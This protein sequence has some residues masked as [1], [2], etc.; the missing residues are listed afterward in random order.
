MPEQL[1]SRN[2]EFLRNYDPLLVEYALK[3]EIEAYGDPNTSLL[4]IRQF[5][6]WLA[7]STAAHAG[8]DCTDNSLDETISLLKRQRII[9]KDVFGLFEQIRLYG[10]EAA[11]E[12]AREATMALRSLICAHELAK[13]F[14]VNIRQNRD[15][16]LEPF[17]PL[18]K[19]ADAHREL[20]EE[21]NF[22]RDEMARSQLAANASE[23]QISELTERLERE[24]IAYQESIAGLSKTLDERVY[25]L[26]RLER[27]SER[28]IRELVPVKN[29]Q[30]FQSFLDRSRKSSQ[31]LGRKGEGNLALTQL[32][33]TTGELSKCCNAPV[34]VVQSMKG[35][36]ITKNCLHCNYYRSF[37]MTEFQELHICVVCADCGQQAEPTKVGS[38][39]GYRCECGWK[40]ELAEIVA[41][42]ADN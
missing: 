2:F 18:P 14:E 1:P 33:I 35:G 30:T 11:H 39:Y 31:R 32:R 27:E 13:W 4:K 5:G 34:I 38:N 19:P 22:L 23:A 3:A 29:L 24:A 36:L 7:K 9:T 25:D 17:K 16:E 26:V 6:E 8:M 15:F 42:Y 41:H 10:N 12:H 37:R 20:E 28:R 21:I 40:C